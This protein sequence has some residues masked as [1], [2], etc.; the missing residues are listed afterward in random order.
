MEEFQK[1]INNFKENEVSKYG[2]LNREIKAMISIVVLTTLGTVK[3][4]KKEVKTSLEAGVLPEL[5]SESAIQCTPYV[6]YSKVEEALEVI[7]VT[8]KE[9]GV[10]L[11]LKK[12]SKTV[13]EK[14]FIKGLSV[15]QSI[16]GKDRIKNMRISE[17]DDLMHIKDYLSAYCFGDFYTRGIVALNVREL[18]TFCCLATLGGCEPQLKAHIAGNLNVGNRRDELLSAITWCIPY[19]GFPRTLNTINCINEIAEK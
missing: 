7:Y 6:G 1:I 8:L 12:Q 15:Q 3:E 13:G 14:R 2:S 10:E 16:F 9:N 19:I 4:I 18:L 17:P 5:L 11:P